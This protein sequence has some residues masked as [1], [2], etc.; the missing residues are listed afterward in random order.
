[1]IESVVAQEADN[2]VS[3]TRWRAEVGVGGEYDTNVSV[4]EVDL[5]SGQSDYAAIID[6]E[7]GVKHTFSER[8]E[9]SLNYDVSQSSY[10][11]FSAVDRMTQILGA[12]INTDLGSSNAALSAY[13]IDSRL[14]GDPFLKYTRISPSLSG[15]LSRRWFARG[16]YVY[17]EREID[18]RSLRDAQ[19]HTG[20][21]D[22]YF[23]HRGLRS[24]FNL[25]YRYRDE[26]AVADAL[27]FDAHSLKLRYIRRVDF[28][29]RKV[30]LEAALRY[31][32]RNYNSDEPTILEPRKDDRMR[33]KLDLEMPLTQ[34]LNWQWYLSYGDYIS[35]LPRADFTQTIL[36]TRLQY[37]W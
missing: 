4:D 24:Y 37:S 15:F 34:K 30:K 6:L 35:N 23:F 28:M 12:D 20:E 3:K 27:D 10:Q 36:G 11:E 31:E 26:D 14:D 2:T 17:S 25:G 16:A 19:T 1:M 13:Y 8:T 22:L 33:L 5:S 9:A 29:D 32:V 21:A 7:L 18:N